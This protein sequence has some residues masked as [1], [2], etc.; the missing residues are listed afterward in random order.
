MTFNV[1]GSSL[2]F[3]LHV[4]LLAQNFEVDFRRLENMFCLGVSVTCGL[5][6]PTYCVLKRSWKAAVV[7]LLRMSDRFEQG[8]CKRDIYLSELPW[9]SI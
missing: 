4:S 6:G 5:L 9:R 1:R 3:L 8:M 2:W 7:K